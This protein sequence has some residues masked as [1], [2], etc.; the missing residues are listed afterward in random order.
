[1]EEQFY[2]LTKHAATL[3]IKKGALYTR[4]TRL[5]KRLHA[6]AVDAG[7]ADG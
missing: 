2:T 5:I 6:L 4:K 7:L 1:M 3:R